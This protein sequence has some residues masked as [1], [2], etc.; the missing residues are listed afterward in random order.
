MVLQKKCQV[1]KAKLTN[2]TKELVSFC[3]FYL[4]NG[5]FHKQML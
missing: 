4:M 1:L 3:Q 5:T 2:I